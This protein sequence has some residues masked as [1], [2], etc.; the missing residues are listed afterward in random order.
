MRAHICVLPPVLH[1]GLLTQAQYKLS[2]QGHTLVG[3]SMLN[4][5]SISN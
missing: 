1:Q 4:V 5:T 3:R 2:I